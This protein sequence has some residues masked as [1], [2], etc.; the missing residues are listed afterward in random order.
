MGGGHKVAAQSTGQVQGSPV[1]YEDYSWES[2]VE[3]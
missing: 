1:Q 3:C 2:C